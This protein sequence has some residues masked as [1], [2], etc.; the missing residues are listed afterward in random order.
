[1]A[2][3][4]DY[5]KMAKKENIKEFKFTNMGGIQQT[6]LEENG[7][8]R[9]KGGSTQSQRRSK[10]KRSKSKRSKKSKKRRSIRKQ[11]RYKAG[12]ATG[13]AVLTTAAL[14]TALRRDNDTLTREAVE[15]SW[16]FDGDFR[17]TTHL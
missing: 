5:L 13:A 11:R 10:S 14:V 7:Q 12:A 16:D 3:Y 17:I 2:S 15:R 4:N 8:F 9:L 1:M 6:Y